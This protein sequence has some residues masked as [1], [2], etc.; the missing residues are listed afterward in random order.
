[1]SSRNP[2]NYATGI[3]PGWSHF[4]IG[5]HVA[6]DCSG[7]QITQT[8]AIK[9]IR[10]RGIV[11]TIALIEKDIAFNPADFM[12]G[13]KKY[14]A[15]CCYTPEEYEETINAVATGTNLS[16][17]NLGKIKPQVMITRRI[18]LERTHQDGFMELIHNK[19]NRIKILVSTRLAS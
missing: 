1:M 6:F 19:D 2:K 18:P 8:T 11:V 16:A 14:V 3:T 4:R 9:A 12:T 15:S 17:I 10:A 13:E 5:P 7:L